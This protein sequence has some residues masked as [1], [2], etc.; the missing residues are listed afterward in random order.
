LHNYC[1]LVDYTITVRWNGDVV[2]CCYDLTSR[3][4]MGNILQDSLESIW[5]GKRYI[6]L[7]R[8]IDGRKFIPLCAGCNKVKPNTYL[9]VKPE[10]RARFTAAASRGLPP[11][12]RGRAEGTS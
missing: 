2:S 9:V 11:P 10:L 1:D 12:G 4:V 8:S 6:G 5:N 7:R 3:Y